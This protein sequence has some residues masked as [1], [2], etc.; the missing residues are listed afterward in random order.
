MGG[1]LAAKVLADD[2]GRDA[3]AT[4]LDEQ[5]GVVKALLRDN[6]HLIQA[7][8]DALIERDELVDREIIEGAISRDGAVVDLAGV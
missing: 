8:R 1:N 6:R 4:L 2:R 3:V 7:L 5:K